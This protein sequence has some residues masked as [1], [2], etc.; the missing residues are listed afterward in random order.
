MTLHIITNYMSRDSQHRER[1]WEEEQLA[2]QKRA[3]QIEE[4]RRIELAIEE[5]DHPDIMNMQFIAARI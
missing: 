3:Q 4:E 1:V 5:L 2:R